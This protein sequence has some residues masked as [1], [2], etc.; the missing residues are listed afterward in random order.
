[1]LA[2][3][4]GVPAD[5]AGSADLLRHDLFDYALAACLRAVAPP[6]LA[7]QAD[8]VARS[9]IERGAGDA[10][11]WAKFASAV[12]DAAT[13]EASSVLAGDRA[14]APRQAPLAFCLAVARSQPTAK[15]LT[16]TTRR[17]A[18][19]YRHRAAR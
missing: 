18:R 1:M 12:R 5:A 3:M 6:D 13:R 16:A 9:V 11:V 14:L 10:A 19:A 2:A 15:A 7:A 4:S 8:L 17:L